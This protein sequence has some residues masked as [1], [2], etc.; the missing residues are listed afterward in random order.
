MALH[1]VRV[2]SARTRRFRSSTWH[3]CPRH[4]VTHVI[5]L[6]APQR[7]EVPPH[8]THHALQSTIKRVHRACGKGFAPW[9]A[10]PP[11][12]SPAASRGPCPQVKRLR[13]GQA[14]AGMLLHCFLTGTPATLS[15]KIIL[16][17]HLCSS[18]FL[19]YLHVRQQ[20]FTRVIARI[21]QKLRLDSCVWCARFESHA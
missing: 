3:E 2:L 12:A 1:H 14:P 9:P 21:E 17:N 19:P 4:C 11:G 18:M 5:A 16:V 7:A 10:S 6:H 13:G 8:A 20:E 15:K